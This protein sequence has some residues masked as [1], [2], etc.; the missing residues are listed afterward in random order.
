MLYTQGA[1]HAAMLKGLP[2]MPAP[3]HSTVL[4]MCQPA[5]PLSLSLCTWVDGGCNSFP[6]DSEKDL[7][8]CVV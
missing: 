5:G 2:L 1:G 6:L 3:L 4:Q 7:L 8:T